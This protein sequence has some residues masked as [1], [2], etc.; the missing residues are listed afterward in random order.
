MPSGWRSSRLEPTFAWGGA[1][2]LRAVPR[3]LQLRVLSYLGP[4]LEAFQKGCERHGCARAEGDINK[5]W[6]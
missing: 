1:P 2:L 4:A 6:N 5:A 3:P